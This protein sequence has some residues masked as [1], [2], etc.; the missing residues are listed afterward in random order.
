MFPYVP[1]LSMNSLFALNSKICQFGVMK[2]ETDFYLFNTTLTRR[3]AALN[4]VGKYLPERVNSQGLYLDVL[5]DY[6]TGFGLAF[7]F[8]CL[9]RQL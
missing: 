6:G 3:V 4:H 7:Y 8:H 5:A 9:L 1:H 2:A